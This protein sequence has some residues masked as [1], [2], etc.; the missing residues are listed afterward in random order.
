MMIFE[1]TYSM[2]P[3]SKRNKYRRY[4]DEEPSIPLSRYKSTYVPYQKRSKKTV[5]P[6][7]DISDGITTR[8]LKATR[9]NRTTTITPLGTLASRSWT[10]SSSSKQPPPKSYKELTSKYPP[11]YY[12]RLINSIPSFTRSI[13]NIEVS[14]MGS[15]LGTPCE[16]PYATPRESPERELGNSQASLS[17]EPLRTPRRGLRSRHNVGSYYRKL[18][19]KRAN[20]PGRKSKYWPYY[21]VESIGNSDVAGLFSDEEYEDVNDRYPEYHE[22]ESYPRDDYSNNDDSYYVYNDAPSQVSDEYVPFVPHRRN[23]EEEEYNPVLPDLPDLAVAPY[24]PANRNGGSGISEDMAF[25]NIVAQT[26]AKA[27][28]ALRN[29]NLNDY[30][31]ASLILSVEGEYTHPERGDVLG[32]H[33][34]ARPI[35]LKGPNL[36]T[37][38]AY[39]AAS[40]SDESS[41]SKY[42][43]TMRDFREGIRQRLESGYAALRDV[44]RSV[45]TY[46]SYKPVEPRS[47]SSFQ[48]SSPMIAS[49]RKELEGGHGFG[50]S[51][52][53]YPLHSQGR[54]ELALP[55]AA[56]EALPDHTHAMDLFDSK[57]DVKLSTLDKIKIKVIYECT[58]LRVSVQPCIV[59]PTFIDIPHDTTILFYV[60]FLLSLV[61]PI[62]HIFCNLTLDQDSSKTLIETLA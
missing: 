6:P 25:H 54:T 4:E 14:P 56:S 58:V 11:D 12:D 57:A 20:Q 48:Y 31:N 39:T 7:T 34:V 27:R 41:F 42:L 2:Q 38:P 19:K 52:S 24:M 29:V 15:P 16:S 47:A 9:P 10:S 32:F 35:P 46:S 44:T 30:D 1:F 51:L 26:A 37:G 60:E 49:Y 62:Y 45:P 5:A 3:P 59:H 21:D 22:Y 17:R 23:F 43:N 28:K 8:H 40:S 53:L 36:A 13:G 55:S 33:Y 61:F 18:L 50:G